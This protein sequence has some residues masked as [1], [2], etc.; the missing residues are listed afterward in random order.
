MKKIIKLI[1]K[2]FL[3]RLRG[4]HTTEDLIKK[5]LIVGSNFK[6]LH[7]TII[8]PAHCW[9]ISI[10]N[11][12]TLAPNVHILAHDASTCYELGYAKIG[13]VEIKDNVFIGAG[14]IVLPDVSIGN[15]VVIGAGSVVTKSI[16]DNSVYAG[17]PARLISS[18][19]EYIQKMREKFNTAYKYDES[20]TLR[21]RNITDEQKNKMN[22]E[23]KNGIGFVV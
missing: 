19:D 11:N 13:K 5:G 20:Y 4:D 6:R 18:Y 15:N 10:G 3:F 1:I 2:R 23:L 17:N 8:D 16:P 22:N 12:V 14:T 9:L 7:G 21:N